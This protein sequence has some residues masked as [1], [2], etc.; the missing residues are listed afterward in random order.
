ME[1]EPRSEERA[2]L[3]ASS[4]VDAKAFWGA[5]KEPGRGVVEQNVFFVLLHPI[6]N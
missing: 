2:W 4:P 6:D 5:V 3:A 1:N